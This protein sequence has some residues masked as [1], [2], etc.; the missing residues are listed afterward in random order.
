MM[1]LYPAS[2]ATYSAGVASMMGDMTARYK[3]IPIKYA[4]E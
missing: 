4:A 3:P 1:F 2:N